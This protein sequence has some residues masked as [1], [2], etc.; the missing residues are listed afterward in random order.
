M[1]RQPETPETS[2]EETGNTFPGLK[3]DL[4]LH[5]EEAAVKWHEENL[6]RIF[7]SVKRCVYTTVQ[8]RR[9]W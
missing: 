8:K 1:L 3:N 9:D 4:R 2:S 7:I 6:L 5:C